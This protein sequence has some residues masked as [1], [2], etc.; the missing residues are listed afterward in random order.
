LVLGKADGFDKKLQNIVLIGE[1]T[2]RL[3]E[4]LDFAAASFEYDADA[5]ITSLLAM[6]EPAL[7]MVMAVV[8]GTVIISVLLPIFQMYDAAGQGVM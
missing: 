8:I 6:L 4:I 2:G 7:L 5:A 3:D 1:E